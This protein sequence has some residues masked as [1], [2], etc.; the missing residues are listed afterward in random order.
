[1]ND[2]DVDFSAENIKEKPSLFAPIEKKDSIVDRLKAWAKKHKTSIKVIGLIIAAAALVLVV[3]IVIICINNTGA[4]QEP[5]S[6]EEIKEII[7]EANAIKPDLSDQVAAEEEKKIV[8]SDI[9]QKADNSDTPEGKL[10][11]NYVK[12]TVLYK[13]GDYHGAISNHLSIIESIKDD[14]EYDYLVEAYSFVADCYEA[15][16]DIESAIKYQELAIACFDTAIEVGRPI[17]FIDRGYYE[18]NLDYLKNL[19]D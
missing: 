10:K 17:T 4:K 14:P 5:V 9:E 19:L 11:L 16:G 7:S 13:Y 2:K 12:S 3:T 6:Y 15:L 8:V 18:Y 1:M